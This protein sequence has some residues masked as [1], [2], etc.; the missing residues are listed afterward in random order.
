MRTFAVFFVAFFVLVS[1]AVVFGAPGEAGTGALQATQLPEKANEI[2]IRDEYPLKDG[3]GIPRMTQ[4]LWDS[5][6][7]DKVI[8]WMREQMKYYNKDDQGATSFVN[9][10]LEVFFP[11]DAPHFQGCNLVDEC[12]VSSVTLFNAGTS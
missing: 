8:K 6:E 10:I 5:G 11:D 2:Q 3:C 4:K 12:S 9:Y 7:G 1:S